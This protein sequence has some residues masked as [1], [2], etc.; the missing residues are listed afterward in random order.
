MFRRRPGRPVSTNPDKFRAIVMQK[1]NKN[2]NTN[3]T[4]NIK[5]ITIN[6]SKSVSYYE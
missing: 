5:N 4:L 1:G 2:N 3:I 6:I